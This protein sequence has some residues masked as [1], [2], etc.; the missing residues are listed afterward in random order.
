MADKTPFL[1]HSSLVPSALLDIIVSE[2]VN[3]IATMSSRNPSAT[4]G[5]EDKD[6]SEKA[7]VDCVSMAGG[8]EPESLR[9]L[10]EDEIKLINRKLV[11]KIDL[12]IL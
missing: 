6:L 2:V 9:N 7:E 3:I 4:G 5:P 8:R 12:V 1:P 11:R 10:S